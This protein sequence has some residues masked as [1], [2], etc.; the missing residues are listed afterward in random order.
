MSRIWNKDLLK[1]IH[2]FQFDSKNCSLVKQEKEINFFCKLFREKNV[3]PIIFLDSTEQVMVR[4]IE[5]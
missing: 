5:K 2:S 3:E 1:F 4:E